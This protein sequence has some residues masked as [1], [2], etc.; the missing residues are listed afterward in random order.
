[1]YIKINTERKFNMSG[2]KPKIITIDLGRYGGT[3]TWTGTV[4]QLPK[5][6]FS[7]KKSNMNP[8]KGIKLGSKRPVGAKGGY[9]KKKVKR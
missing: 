9:M 3:G 5:S 4:T 7:N 8:A 2:T 6:G 1:M